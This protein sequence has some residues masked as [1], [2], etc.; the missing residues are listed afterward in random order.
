MP[1]TEMAEHTRIFAEQQ[2][3]R[4][5]IRLT[6]ERAEE[7]LFEQPD[8]KDKVVHFRGADITCFSKHALM[9]LVV[10]LKA[11]YDRETSRRQNDREIMKLFHRSNEDG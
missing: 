7:W 4:N 11:M 8:L 5:R 9:R 1:D 6:A 10:M 3:E 2:C